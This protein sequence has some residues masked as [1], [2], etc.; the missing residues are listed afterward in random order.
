[1]SKGKY[2]ITKKYR[3]VLEKQLQ[4]FIP[5]PK[6]GKKEV[7]TG[8]K[9]KVYIGKTESLTHNSSTPHRQAIKELQDKYTSKKVGSVTN[10]KGN[11]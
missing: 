11:K 3:N 2:T 7:Y 8:S 4:E 1:M 6:K 9:P 5:I 10:V